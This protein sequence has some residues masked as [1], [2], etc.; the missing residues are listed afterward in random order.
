VTDEPRD[1]P[2]GDDAPA[3]DAAP[4]PRRPV[5]PVGR[6]VRMGCILLAVIGGV[7]VIQGTMLALDPEDAVCTQARRVLDDDAADDDGKNLEDEALDEREE[8]I[9]DLECEAAVA[10]AEAVDDGDV[11]SE[12]AARTTGLLFAGVGLA[13]LVIGLLLLR[14]HDNR[15]RIAALVV[16]ALGILVP[17]LGIFSIPMLAFVVYALGFS[18]D[19]K[20]IFGGGLGRGRAA[21]PADPADQPD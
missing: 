10:E 8:E 15:L 9:D 17:A 21:P 12:G 13:Q 3:G 7:G 11:P 18:A 4:A 16:C 20:A 6:I 2:V 19:S 1:E 5:R 14:R